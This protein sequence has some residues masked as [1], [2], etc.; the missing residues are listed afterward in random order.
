MNFS[1]S[2]RSPQHG[3]W[4]WQS[5]QLILFSSHMI[6]APER[7]PPRFPADKV[8]RTAQRISQTLQQLQAGPQDQALTQG[9]S[10]GD[11]LFAEACL[12]RGV[13]LQLLQPFAE[14][15]LVENS[16][17]LARADF[18]EAPPQHRRRFGSSPLAAPAELGELSPN[19]NPDERCNHWLLESVLAYGPKNSLAS[20]CGTA[21]AAT[22]RA[23]R[24]T[25]SKRSKNTTAG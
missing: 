19:M 14:V 16:V 4:N 12:Q 22:V 6:D 20:A 2:L 23:A 18:A 17:K 15:E 5:R 1:P 9:A 21:V 7:N 8:P 11:I 10:G 25:C 3:W 24:R 13:K